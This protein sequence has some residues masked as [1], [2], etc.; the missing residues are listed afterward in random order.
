MNEEGQNCPICNC[1]IG[2][3]LLWP[4][5]GL[6]CP[7]C[8]V[9][10][11][12]NPA[13]VGLFSLLLFIYFGIVTVAIY[14]TTDLLVNRMSSYVYMVFWMVGG[15]CIWFPFGFFAAFRLRKN[16]KLELK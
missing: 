15:C 10:L 16:S 8:R 7:H 4:D 1:D 13:G 14:L 3:R 12:Y 6:R 11:K 5:A 2:I 9:K